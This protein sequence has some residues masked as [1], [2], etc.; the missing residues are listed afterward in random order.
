MSR[1][2]SRLV[3]SNVVVEGHR[4]SIRLEPELWTT[5]EKFARAERVTVNAIV[6]QAERLYPGGRTSAVRMFM[7]VYLWQRRSRAG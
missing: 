1:E 4:A 7:V 6:T 2:Q 3:N 5:L